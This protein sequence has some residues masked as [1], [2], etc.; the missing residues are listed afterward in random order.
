M[1]FSEIGSCP[2]N[3]QNY[4][5]L[6]NLS[7]AVKKVSKRVLECE[8]T[9]I[10][11]PKR[12]EKPR[13]EL[14][15]DKVKKVLVLFAVFCAIKPSMTVAM[16]T[17]LVTNGLKLALLGAVAGVGYAVWLR[18]HPPEEPSAGRK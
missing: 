3:S 2:Q 16:V 14:D 7:K 11:R 15:M 6:R 10:E 4:Q 5:G 18:L 1:F 13:K 12:K 9:P 8:A 17:F